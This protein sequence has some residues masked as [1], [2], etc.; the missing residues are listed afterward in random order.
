MKERFIRLIK[1]V[2]GKIST[3]K[4]KS[5]RLSSK[6]IDGAS[7]MLVKHSG[8]AQKLLSQYRNIIIWHCINHRLELA[9]ADSVDEVVVPN[10]STPISRVR[11]KA[12]PSNEKN[13]PY[14]VNQVGG[15]FVPN[16]FSVY[17][18]KLIKRRIRF[19]E[20]LK[21]KPGTR[22]LEAQ[23]AINN[24]QFCSVPLTD[25]TKMTSI[26]QQQLS[27]SAANNLKKSLLRTISSHGSTSASSE[28]DIK[29]VQYE[30]KFNQIKVLNCDQC[31]AICLYGMVKRR[32]RIFVQDSILTHPRFK[33]KKTL[34]G[35]ILTI[36]TAFL[37]N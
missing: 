5:T 28:T 11:C 13:R 26:N 37:K 27:S 35:T 8:V 32:Y 4:D 34:T 25:N 7:V 2:S 3:I 14:F 12:R 6:S 20:S 9:L 31:H 29:N 15:Q 36:A 16:S 22:I 1:G 21:E 17:A 10:E 18:D 33:K 30:M 24:G 23:I 19:I